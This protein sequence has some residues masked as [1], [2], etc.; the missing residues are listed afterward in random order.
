MS[1]KDFSQHFPTYHDFE[2]QFPSHRDF[3]QRFPSEH[4]SSQQFSEN[5]PMN[6]PPEAIFPA[7][8]QQPEQP[9]NNPPA[10]NPPQNQPDAQR[11]ALTYEEQYHQDMQEVLR[12]EAEEED[13]RRTREEYLRAKQA[14][15]NARCAW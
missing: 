4:D 8:Q 9:V 5:E 3:F 15:R 7:F 2:Q 1:R 6:T 11:R 14:R 10:N 12:A 13:E